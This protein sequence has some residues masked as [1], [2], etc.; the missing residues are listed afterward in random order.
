MSYLEQVSGISLYSVTSP[1]RLLIG[2]IVM[3]IGPDGARRHDLTL[4]P[5]LSR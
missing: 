1:A 2:V 4:C 3:M 5:A